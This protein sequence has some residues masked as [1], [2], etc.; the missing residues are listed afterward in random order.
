MNRRSVVLYI[1]TITYIEKHKS[2]I[3]ES[4]KKIYF[5]VELEV[6]S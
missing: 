1:G 2:Y 6:L 5:D 4:Q 3:R